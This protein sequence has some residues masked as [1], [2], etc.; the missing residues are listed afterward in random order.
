M[1]QLN[2]KGATTKPTEA[3]FL[4]ATDDT[5]ENSMPAQT[6]HTDSLE[7]HSTSARKQK[8]KVKEVAEKLLSLVAVTSVPVRMLVK[9][10]LNARKKASSDESINELADNI[11]EIGLLQN[12]VIYE[13]PG[14][15]KNPTTYGVAAGGRRHR[16]FNVLVSRKYI[17]DNHLVAV[18][19][20]DKSV[21]RIVSLAENDLREPMH[22]ADQ[23]EAFRVLAEANK[24][25]QAIGAMFGYSTKHVQRMLKLNKMAPELL[26]LLAKDEITVDQLQALAITDDHERQ[27]AAWN[28]GSYYSNEN[29]RPE[30]L[31]R[32]VL[33]NDRPIADDSKMA[34]VGVET[35]QAAGGNVNFDLFSDT[36]NGYYTDAVLLDK[37]TMD[38]L[39][40]YADHIVQQ[41][42]WSWG[43]TK[44]QRIYY[45]DDDVKKNYRLLQDPTPVLLP[46]DNDRID[47]LN[48][49]G[50]ML[51]EYLENDL[52]ENTGLMYKNAIKAMA[53]ELK[54][55]Q[56]NA[57]NRAWPTQ[58]REQAGIIVSFNRGEILVQRGIKCITDEEKAAER[59]SS[60]RAKGITGKT[61]PAA[62][63]KSL[64]SARSLA[65]SAAL[66]QQH[67]IALVMVTHRFIQAV[68]DARF[69]SSPLTISIKAQREQMINNAP[70]LIDSKANEELIAQHK[71]WHARFPETWSESPAWL[72]AWD[73]DEL[74][75]LMAY[76][77]ACSIDGVQEQEGSGESTLTPLEDLL[78]FDLREY[79]QPTADN[80]F[81]RVNK[82]V[83]AGT[84]YE[85]GKADKAVMIANLKKGEGAALAETE[86]KHSHWIPGIL[87]R[88]SHDAGICNADVFDE[89]FGVEEEDALEISLSD[90]LA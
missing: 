68:F 79:W 43:M 23:V 90:K 60:K 30:V 21:A 17:T 78:D 47:E 51:H 74:L 80:F 37:L 2:V 50:V 4:N 36:D 83:I 32:Q 7:N 22:P 41:E 28:Q 35:Y 42:G 70:T 58:I 1:A 38:K 15:G 55:I 84:L 8:A 46:E 5:E 25:P 26:A 73:M 63:V 48:E 33:D 61:L 52:S 3:S 54:D 59:E 18:K 49:K 53:E 14:K 31:R 75:G 24:K 77:V 66:N 82:E 12:L 64:T 67:K 89:D 72:M 6:A 88:A 86:M 71:A 85:A 76:C 62:L 10:E 27:C 44:E 45:W 13:I 81:K 39:Q 16:A 20:V 29:R 56:Q 34:Y 9:S 87:K 19:I 40:V 57:V 69:T 11:L 65:V